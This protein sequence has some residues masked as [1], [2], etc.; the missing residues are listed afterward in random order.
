[1]AKKVTT[2]NAAAP[3]AALS[4]PDAG[5]R[6]WLSVANLENLYDDVE[7]LLVIMRT[8]ML[9]TMLTHAER[10]RLLGSGVRRYGFIDKTSD[11]AAAN[12]QFAPAFFTSAKL[13]N[14]IREIELLRNIS[15]AL[16]QMQR[17]SDDVLLMVSDEAFQMAL[18]YYNTVREAARR[19]QPGAQEIFRQLQ[20]FFRRG[21]R[22]EEEPTEPEVERDVRAL[23]K[24]R[25]E[26]R[27][28][29]EKE[30]PHL[31]GGKSVV[32]DEIRKPHG[33]WKATEEGEIQ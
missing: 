29:I 16:A 9:P 22:D 5:L 33:E 4:A 25:K 19:R 23:L 32:A 11:I 15:G 1:M 3:E 26:G 7:N 17:I 20:L 12:P 13:K 18:A 27:I 8:D 24:G 31:A 14:V 21:R 28:L 30:R 2:T 10:M 6:D